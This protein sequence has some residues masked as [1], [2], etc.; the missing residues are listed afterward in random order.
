MANMFKFVN[1]K[2]QAKRLGL[3]KRLGQ[4]SEKG[5]RQRLI[6]GRVEIDKNK[7]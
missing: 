6:I 1:M 3:P 7:F 2:M 5:P 4:L